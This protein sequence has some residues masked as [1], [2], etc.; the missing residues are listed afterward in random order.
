MIIALANRVRFVRALKSKPFAL[1]WTGQ[2]ISA[3]GDGA[4]DTALAW[5]VLILTG[6]GTAMGIVLTAQ[7]IPT[8]V[9]LLIGGAIA[10]QLPRRL[11]M[12]W[13]DAGRAI[14][15]LLIAALGWLHLLQLWHL[16]ALALFFG[17]VDGFFRPAY[18]AIFPQLVE[19][20]HLPSANALTALSERISLLV[21]PLLGALYVALAGP[22]SAFA[23]DGLTFVISALCLLVMRV[24][25]TSALVP[26]ARDIQVTSEHRGIAGIMKSIFVDVR[27]GLRYVAGSEW[28]L[29][30]LPLATLGNIGFVATA[31]AMPKLV[32]DVYGAGVWL[33]GVLEM[34]SGLG[35]IVATL[36]VGQIR[37][38]HRRGMLMY[39]SVILASIAIAVLGLPLPKVSATIGAQYIAPLANA[40]VGFGLGA[41][42]V[43]WVTVMQEMVPADKLGRVTSIDILGAKCLTPVGYALGGLITDRV[44]PGWVFIFA[45]TLNLVLNVFAL[46]VPEIRE[47]D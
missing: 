8:L 32:H 44:G 18:R 39:L 36:I 9:F 29:V 13:S 15:V 17:I 38:L 43:I 26:L 22:A 47:V 37:H 46:C 31:V 20:E 6:S 30:G 45:G 25:V 19:T 16:V 21:G 28:F 1:L 41:F 24:P 27:E 23:F 5:Q 11:V 14:L 7:M 42:G 12:F 40:F 3:L 34:S 4:F 10:D 35:A 2:T 33:L